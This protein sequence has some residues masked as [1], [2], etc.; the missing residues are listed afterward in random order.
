M[1]EKKEK[2][3]E[4]PSSTSWVVEGKLLAGPVPNNG[5]SQVLARDV[6][7]EVF[8]NLIKKDEWDYL[9]NI[10]FE[11]VQDARKATNK[12]IEMDTSFGMTDHTADSKT[13]AGAAKRLHQLI[14]SGKTTYLHCLGGYGR[15]GTVTAVYLGKYCGMDLKAALARAEELYKLRSNRKRK[16]FPESEEQLAVVKEILAQTK[17]ES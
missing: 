13:V 16:R 15:T 12:K 9:C 17:T 8:M 2:E 11:Y 4:I 6:G 3:K 7:V 14:E 1:A 10:G 5:L